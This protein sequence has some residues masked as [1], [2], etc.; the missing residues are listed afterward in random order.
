M[1]I[2]SFPLIPI[3]SV[4]GIAHTHGADQIAVTA[5]HDLAI[6][7]PAE[8]IVV[9]WTEVVSHLPGVAADRVAVKDAAGKAV[10]SQVVNLQPENQG[11]A[12][13]LIF[14]HDFAAGEKSATFTV[15]KTAETPPKVPTKTFGRYVPER[16]DDFAWEN[17]RIAHRTYGPKL[18][19]PAAG[20]DQNASSGIDVWCKRV[21]ESII[22]HWYAK[23]HYHDD[24]GEGLDMYEV[25]KSRGCGGTGIWDGKKLHASLGW[26]SWKVLSNG[27]LRTVFELGYEPWDAGGTQVSEIK[28]FTV[29]AGQNLNRVESTF[30]FKGGSELTVAIGIAK[31]AKNIKSADPVTKNEKAGALSLWERY[32]KDGQLG[33]AALV[34]AGGLAGFAEDELNHLVLTKAKSGQPVRY[35]IGAG[36]NKSGDFPDKTAWGKYLLDFALRLKSPVKTTVSNE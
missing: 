8:T 34:G 31:H 9:P 1:K 13:E 32:T 16:F 25:G 2:L 33:T 21:R 6:A 5:T 29:D 3:L 28:R 14:Q 18:E 19:T 17:D 36:W 20:K 24:T 4:L 10:P 22:D 35:Y 23:A 7:R 30:N 15:E 12:D 27:P 26:R 11:H